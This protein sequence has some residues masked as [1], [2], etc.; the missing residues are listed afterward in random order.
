MKR[1]APAPGE[2]VFRGARGIELVA[3]TVDGKRAMRFI[4]SDESV[5]RYGD[6][7]R[8]EGWQLEAYRANPVLLFAHNSHEP[9][10]GSV[11]RIFVEGTRLIADAVFDDNEANVRAN[12]VWG[13]LSKG[14]MRAVSVGFAPTGKI[15]E[16]VDDKGRWTGYE[17]TSQELHELSVVPVPA[18]PAAL[19]I[20]KSFGIDAATARA[21]FDDTWRASARAAFEQ[22]RRNISIIRLGGSP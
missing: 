5:D 17:F 1:A 13:L 11:E 18:N 22:R 9:A 12:V 15:N 2:R 16:L 7:I 6:I 10:I 19:A 21:L 3:E 4:A 20:A 8:A 14:H